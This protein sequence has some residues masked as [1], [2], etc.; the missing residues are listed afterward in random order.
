[1]FPPNTGM[2]VLCEAEV[3]T[4]T[5]TLPPVC[6]YFSKSLSKEAGT[7]IKS[8]RTTNAYFESG[9]PAAW[10]A[11]VVSTVNAASAP[12]ASAGRKFVCRVDP[13]FAAC[14][15]VRHIERRKLSGGASVGGY[16]DAL[17]GNRLAVHKERDCARC[18]GSVESGDYNLHA[19]FLRV[20]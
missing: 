8:E 4:A 19:R 7:E 11:L 2:R 15:A 1:M 18:G 9:R 3:P 10:A 14:E 17:G 13:H 16:G 6:T 12:D 20:P 5:Q